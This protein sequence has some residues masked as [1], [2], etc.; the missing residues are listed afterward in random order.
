MNSHAVFVGLAG[1][2]INCLAAYPAER[3]VLGLGL[4][5]RVTLPLDK[6]PL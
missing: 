2:Q 5:H 3:G 4:L 6:A 1:F